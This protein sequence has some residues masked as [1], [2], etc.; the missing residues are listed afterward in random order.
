[1]CVHACVHACVRT[2]VCVC[3]CVCGTSSH[4]WFHLRLLSQIF[5]N[6]LSNYLTHEWREGKC[7]SC[8]EQLV[9]VP[10]KLPTVFVGV[11]IEQPTPFLQQVLDRLAALNYPKKKMTVFLRNSVSWQ[12]ITG[13]RHRP[14]AHCPAVDVK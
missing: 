11:F 13:D 7:V 6:Y 8:V 9:A 1:M 4:S 3:V 12:W 2:C 10:Q 5:L 14:S